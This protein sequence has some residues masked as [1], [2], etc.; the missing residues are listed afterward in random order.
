MLHVFTDFLTPI[1]HVTR[2]SH[3]AVTGLCRALI[4]TGLEADLGVSHP[5]NFL[6][7]ELPLVLAGHLG[8]DLRTIVFRVELCLDQVER[9]E[10]NSKR[11]KC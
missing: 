5:S 10:T 9:L 7:A 2:I 3:P 6:L 1:L 8:P 11:I 4:L